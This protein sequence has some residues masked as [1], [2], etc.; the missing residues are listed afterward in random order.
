[1]PTKIRKMLSGCHAPTTEADGDADLA[2]DPISG[3]SELVIA[4]ADLSVLGAPSSRREAAS[5]VDDKSLANWPSPRPS[6]PSHDNRVKPNPVTEPDASA[7]RGTDAIPDATDGS[8]DETATL[9]TEFTDPDEPVN[10]PRRVAAIDG[11]SDDADE[12]TGTTGTA[13]E[14]EPSTSGAAV[15]DGNT[16][17]AE[18]PEL[19][20]PAI[21]AAD[22]APPERTDPADSPPAAFEEPT[23]GTA[24]RPAR[25]DGTLAFVDVDARASAV[26]DPVDPADPVVSANAIG[27]AATAE[28]IPRAAA[29][30]PTRPTYRENPLSVDSTAVGARRPYSMARTRPRAERR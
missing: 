26:P 16:V 21:T 15:D 14:S 25:R 22:T 12:S 23:L 28:P 7:T 24:P 3:S 11:A 13:T 20:R 8:N 18:C 19:R 30:A 17:A 10:D 5:A 2:A 29:N 1:L 6:A 27:I 4:V 9:V